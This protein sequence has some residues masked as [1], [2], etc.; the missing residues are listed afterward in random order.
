MGVVRDLLREKKKPALVAGF[1][2]TGCRQLDPD[3]LAGPRRAA[4]TVS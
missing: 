2:V 4:G 1:G 3:H